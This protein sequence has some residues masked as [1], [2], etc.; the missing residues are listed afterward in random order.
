[1]AWVTNNRSAASERR[2]RPRESIVARYR[3]WQPYFTGGARCKHVDRQI[4]E[5]HADVYPRARILKT[6]SPRPLAC[7]RLLLRIMKPYSSPLSSSSTQFPLSCSP[8]SSYAAMRGSRRSI[9]RPPE[10]VHME[11]YA[12]RKTHGQGRYGADRSDPHPSRSGRAGDH[13]YASIYNRGIG[14]ER[15]AMRPM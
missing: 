6:P 11:A 13:G 1:M 7:R 10:P 3:Y 4:S 9:E 12:Q 14:C 8:C 5:I 2:G 15:R